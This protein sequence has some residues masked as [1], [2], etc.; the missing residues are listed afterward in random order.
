MIVEQN[1]TFLFMGDS[2]TDVNRRVADCNP[3]GQGYPLLVAALVSAKY[4]ELNIRFLNRGIGGNTAQDLSDRWETDVLTHK[5]D[6]LSILIGINDVHLWLKNPQNQTVSPEAF[7]RIYH[8]LLQKTAEEVG[9]RFILIEPFYI[10]PDRTH[11][12]RKLLD[13]YREI[14]R[15]VAREFSALFIPAQE[16]FDALL[17]KQPAAYWTQDSVHPAPSGH[18]ALARWLLNTLQY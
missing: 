8:A 18:G 5:P 16:E 2:I 11:P 15:S 10:H 7:A 4:P 3:L 14:V 13:G 9:N 17:K 12:V 1:Q 6:W